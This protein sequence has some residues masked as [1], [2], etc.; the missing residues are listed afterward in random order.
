MK[1]APSPNGALAERS[2]V[3]RQKY[4]KRPDGRKEST[5]TINGKRYH[6]Y[7]FTDEEIDRQKAEL[8]RADENRTLYIDQRTTFPEYASK[9]LELIR[10]NKEARTMEMYERAVRLLSDQIGDRVISRLT[11]DDLQLA[12][13]S[14]AIHPRTQQQ[15]Y[16][17]VNQI[18]ESAINNDMLSKNPCNGLTHVEYKAPEKRALTDIE[19]AAV[20]SG[21]LAPQEQLFVDFLYY[22]GLRREEALALSVYDID[23]KNW[24][25]RIHHVLVIK[26]D[27]TSELKDCPKTPA[28]ERVIP[29]P[30]QLREH[31]K[32]YA[33]TLTTSP[34]FFVRAKSA[35]ELHN[36]SSY[37]RFWERILF[38]LN[39]AAGGVNQY[40]KEKGRTEMIINMV[41]GLTAHTFRH[42]YATLL[43]KKGVNVKTA[44]RLLGHASIQTTLAIYT[45]LE[46]NSINHELIE[47]VF[48]DDVLTTSRFENIS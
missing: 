36:K 34:H 28:G 19:T 38:K 31:I 11:R 9:W 33:D 1:R 16:V 29:I 3:R 12:L 21:C 43:F 22:C 15:M 42:N 2:A 10:P 48:S 8:I 13:N 5:I 30:S 4:K 41:P 32:E 37:R 47:H 27:G 7:G 18:F 17:T 24:M 14:Q 26:S 46:A 45:H 20:L 39:T 44:Q 25:L 35:T 6:V 23:R 40:N